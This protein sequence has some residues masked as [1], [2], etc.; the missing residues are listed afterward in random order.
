[1]VSA[2]FALLF[3]ETGSG[4]V[5]QLQHF[6]LRLCLACRFLEWCCVMALD[7]L[8]YGSFKPTY[9][10][11]DPK[12]LPGFGGDVQSWADYKFSVMAIEKKENYLSEGE[13][14]KL[15]PLGLRLIDRLAGPALQ[16]AK[17]MGLDE[18]AKENGARE[19]LK[20]L[21]E[22]LMP[23]KKQAAMELYHAGMKDG[24]LSRQQGE[25]MS[26]YCMRREAWWSQLQELDSSVQCSNAILGEQL[27]M[28]SGLGTMEMQMV[29][30]V[31]QNDL[32]DMMKLTNTLRDQFGQIHEK[33][34]RGGKGGKGYQRDGYRS[35]SSRGSTA[36]AA[37]LHSGDDQGSHEDGYY[38]AS[39]TYSDWQVYEDEESYYPDEEISGSAAED[40]ARER[41][42]EEEVVAWYAQQSIDSQTCSAEDL[43]M[44]ID[45]VEA[46][47]VSY[48]TKW[49]SEQRGVSSPAG[50]TNYGTSMSVADRQA[51]V[52]AAKQRS[53]CRA[54]GQV[55]HWQRDPICPKR[56]V[57]GKGKK[58]G[59][60]GKPGGKN[61][62]DGK[63]GGKS[64]KGGSGKKGGDKPRIVYF[65]IAEHANE[66]AESYMALREEQADS[67]EPLDERQQRAL[68]QEVQR[69]MQLPQEQ[70]NQM[71]EN[72]L[73]Y[74]TPTSKAAP[75]QR[76]R[77]PEFVALTPTATPKTS[78]PKATMPPVPAMPMTSSTAM[79]SAGCLHENVTRRGTNAYVNMETCM[80][81]GVV[82]KKEKK[83]TTKQDKPMSSSTPSEC[84]HPEN[85]VS[86]R[87][88]N[89]Y[90]W[91]W[92]CE[93]CGTTGSHKKIPGQPRPV[94]GRAPREGADGEDAEYH[95]GFEPT[96]VDE[97]IFAT[98]GRWQQFSNVLN[99]MVVS[100]IGI[101]GGVTHRD[102]LH[103]VNASV[104]CFRTLGGAAEAMQPPAH[105]TA[106]PGARST[107]SAATT[108]RTEEGD[109]SGMNR[110]TFGKYKRRTFR[111][112]YDEDQDYVQWALDEQVKGQAYCSNMERFQ[113]FCHRERQRAWE[114][115][116]PSVRAPRL[117][118][119]AVTCNFVE[120]TTED[121]GLMMYL[122]SGCNSTCHG[123]LWMKNFE[124]MTGYHP[125]WI[126]AI[127]KSMTGIGGSTK[128]LGTRKLYVGLE[129][130]E[131]YYV[132]G[133]L[134]SME[135]EGSHA[136]LLLS[137]QAQQDLG[138]VI[139]LV[140]GTVHSKTLK[141]T[142]KTIRG[143]KN[144]LLGI[145]LHPGE[146]LEDHMTVPVALMAENEEPPDD[147]RWNRDGDW[148]EGRPK[149]GFTKT[150]EV[151]KVPNRNKRSGGNP[152]DSRPITVYSEAI[153][154]IEAASSSSGVRLPRSPDHPPPQRR[155]RDEQKAE[156]STEVADDEMRVEIEMTGDEQ[157]DLEIEVTETVQQGAEDDEFPDFEIP[158][159]EQEETEA[160]VLEENGEESPQTRT[161]GEAAEEEHQDEFEE[162][163][164]DFTDGGRTPTPDEPGAEPSAEEDRQDGDFWEL[165]EGGF[166]IRHHFRPRTAYFNPN[167]AKSSM[168]IDI[169]RIGVLRRTNMRFVGTED[170]VDVW[171]DWVTGEDTPQEPD[172]LWTGTT[173][174]YVLTLDENLNEQKMKWDDGTRR[175]MTRGQKKRLAKEVELIEEEDRAMW[176]TLRKQRPS[177]PRGWKA[178][179][180]IFAGCAVMTAV[181]QANGY[182]CCQPLDIKTGWNVFDP[183]DRKFA[184]DTIDREKPYL[185][186]FEFPCGPW[187]P[188]QR[189]S[190][191]QMEVYEKRRVWIPVFAW[192]KKVIRKHQLR[193]GKVLLENPWPSEA[194]MTDEMKQILDL[195]MIS[196]KIDMCHFGLRDKESK[197]LHKKS[198]CIATDSCGI[199]Q[200]L[201]GCECNRRHQHEPLEGR[202]R[203]GSR[204]AQAA[205]YTL[206]FCRAI[207][208]G[209]Q[210]D[211][212]DNMCYA[213]HT[214]D[215]IEAAEEIEDKQTLD[216]VVTTEDL[217][218]NPSSKAELEK[219]VTKE[220]DLEL[221]DKEADP[222]SEKMRKREWRKLSRA[223][224]VGIRRLH[225]M[226]SHATRSQM[227]RMLKYANA[228]HNVLRGVRHFRCPACDRIEPEKRPQVVKPPDPYVFNESIGMDIVTVK[229]GLDQSFHLLHVMC[230]GT[231]FHVGEIIGPAQ[232]VPSSSRCLQALLRMWISWAGTPKYI[233]VDRGTHNRG[234]LMSE[235]EKRG[236]EFRLVALEAPYQLGKVERGGGILK[237]MIKR[238]A[239]ATTAIGEDELQMVLSECLEVKNRQGNVAGFSPSQWVIGRNPRTYGWPDDHTDDFANVDDPDPTSQFNRRGAMREA[240]KAAWAAEGSH[241]RIRAAVLRKDG[242]QQ[243]SFRQGDMVSFMRRQKTGG[244]IGPARVLA[245]DGKNV[246]LLHS[247]I[248]I[249]VAS[250]RVRGANAE[251][252]L[253]TELLNKSR[254]SRKR[255]FLERDAVAQPHRL[256]DAGQQPFM[257][258]RG[259]VGGAPAAI[260]DDNKRARVTSDEDAAGEAATRAPAAPAALEDK[261][262][263]EKQ[264]E[265]ET[266]LEA[267]QVPVPDDEAGL[268]IDVDAILDEP[269]QQP[270]GEPSHPPAES[271]ERSQLSRAMAIDGGDRLDLGVDRSR[272]KSNKSA[273]ELTLERPRSRSPM[274]ESK[275]RAHLAMS[276]E[277]VCFLAKRKGKADSH[278]IVYA[279]ASEE[280][281][282]KLNE[283]RAKEWGNWLKYKAVRFPEPEELEQLQASGQQV[284]PMRWVDVD[285]N[286]KLRIPGGPPVP[287][288]LKSRLVIR[289]D[290]EREEFRTDC[291]T[292]SSGCVH[293]LLSFAACNKRKLKSGDITAA[294]PQGSP[295]ERLLLLSAPKDGIPLENGEMIEPLTRM[296][297]QMS[298]YGSK[299]APRGFWLALRS[300]L[301]Q[302]GLTEVAPAFYVLMDEGVTR[303]LLC[304]H[305][306]DLLWTGDEK[307]DETMNKV[308][309]RFTFGSTEE[310]SF[311]F[312]GRMITA[313]EEKISVNSP[314]TLAKV[315]PI[316]IEGGRQRGHTEAAT[317]T[318]ISQMRG[319]LGSI[320]WVAKLCRPEL[321]YGC[322]AL[323]GKQTKAKV[324]DL[325]NTNKLLSAAQKTAKNGIHFVIGKFDF[326][327]TILLSVTDASHA[328]EVSYTAVGTEQGHRSQ[329]GRF[330]LLA[331]HMPTKDSPTVCH[332]LEW[333]SQ[334]LKRVC[335]STLQAEV[336][337]SMLGS[338]SAQQMRWLLYSLKYPRIPESRSYEWKIQAADS[339]QVIWLSDCRSFIDYMGS[340]T[341]TTVSDKRLAIDMTSL[342]QELWRGCGEEVG[343]PSA[344]SSM[345]EEARDQLWW[346]CT[347]DMIAD[348][349]TKSMRRDAVRN[350]VEKN[351]LA[352]SVEPI[353]A[354]F[355]SNKS[356][357][358]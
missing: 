254:L 158:S 314:E 151:K 311:R 88:T 2:V 3:L 73:A 304:S 228:D 105:L 145:R 316:Y 233:L 333:S 183:K 348:E 341:P 353:R 205:Q 61:K 5:L 239:V 300:T 123:E 134:T 326:E 273:A 57:K 142:F 156:S 282:G 32:S 130:D 165:Q 317:E 164:T 173:T 242:A 203:F 340:L 39:E 83:E 70:L 313:D 168:P 38:T 249:L 46:E 206:K 75:A 82:L 155:R 49:Q 162:D 77:M 92:S 286:E 54:C 113:A 93:K 200:V 41:E 135:I 84:D 114:E 36:Y 31:C 81:C 336:L 12:A 43:E 94:P 51:K 268:D 59:F 67:G 128:S 24:I 291:P 324:E 56:N 20:S 125:E 8:R 118:F 69:L 107:T 90:A 319:V 74:M 27:L 71:M 127:A 226:T 330:L 34:F 234:V 138:L 329:G 275:H 1:M 150:Y 146:F 42:I 289:G 209:V 358:V 208:E 280:M 272:M 197:R 224:R 190:P 108:M 343:D 269:I 332:V 218:L 116:D 100:H 281:Q 117:G 106:S 352:L 45:A 176:S 19:L 4:A 147:R 64:P 76:P 271:A 187:S 266:K 133:E 154:N 16:V 351:L 115:E 131:D 169:T 235:M 181:F 33:E 120:G 148:H 11:G 210:H 141:C 259:P 30:T 306:D 201:H 126:D 250:N 245:M 309:E 265:E 256:E 229:D 79:A 180:E 213:F 260:E 231:C 194:W 55:G 346:I 212:Q 267:S 264:K 347:H 195:G 60:K 331:D 274:D 171:D 303:G 243:E 241:R 137:L 321:C 172:S 47:V 136:P 325:R 335:R 103:I 102:F 253:E 258:M 223:A 174:F 95:G 349:L 310:G 262:L 270:G 323:Q 305:V 285:K 29:R 37:D 297:A 17:K 308:Q 240:A 177:F 278:E 236:V 14:K 98:R 68:E 119:M 170:S 188:W 337:S 121:E 220:E 302:V 167:E 247:G 227:T 283:S 198:T 334:T 214:E 72:E 315:K 328:A 96:G 122:D 161:D 112:V 101:H 296:V 215:L 62:G 129:T 307:M 276:Q 356:T 318:E 192:M 216:D 18:L 44:V 284:V 152:R 225:H 298:V 124:M 204:C 40:D 301:L 80:D 196:N 339:K 345:P 160:F 157:E 53:R 182:E 193:G 15:G 295:I 179:M 322:S 104:L 355:Q 109:I 277:F 132:P 52:L 312:C 25:S 344:T 246:W 232:G 222:T 140:D 86:W 50:G 288:K 238:T 35:W 10:Q 166:L 237:G 299:D 144:R 294:F 175:V 221:L 97:M 263:E 178:L 78:M 185:L 293:V 320:G 357:G 327:D 159:A 163:F 255:P 350:V 287:E 202:N 189:M 99:T 217:C 91:K 89:G 261:K 13:K 199:S 143:C 211:L 207:L 338:E 9:V 22:H 248:P 111:E 139:D 186:S 66:K 342:R 63:G 184:E 58:G 191:N 219:T 85:M 21:E 65:S 279:R 7:N 6:E 230:L 149:V 153:D 290:L 252:H 292:A 26:S 354:G 28:H 110:I 244:W 23:L 251:E 257:D 87:G 48:Y